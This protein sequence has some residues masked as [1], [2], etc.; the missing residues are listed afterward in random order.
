MLD[1]S[2]VKFKTTVTNIL[3]ALMD[4]DSMQEQ[5]GNVSRDGNLKKEPKRSARDQNIVTE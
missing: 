4:I 3:G 1:L 5:K 2:D